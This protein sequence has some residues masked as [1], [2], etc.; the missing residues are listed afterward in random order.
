VYESDVQEAR[1]VTATTARSVANQAETTIKTADSIVASIVERVEAEGTGPE[2]RVRFYRLM[3]SLA[4][5]LPAIHE[6]GI[7]DAD[8]NAIVKSLVENSAG[9]NYSDREY[10]RYH[11]THTDRGPFIG[12]RIKSK[13]DGS[14]AITVTRRINHADGSF[15]GVVV[16]SVS[17]NFFQRLFD[18]VLAKSGGIIALLTDD[19]TVLV[20]SPNLASGIGNPVADSEFRRHVQEEP[21]AGGL[22]YRSALDGVWRY[23]SYQH[24]SDFPLSTL[25]SQSE[26]E[27]QRSFRSQLMWNAAILVC[28][29]VVVVNL[30]IRALKANRLLNAQAMQDGLTGLANRRTFDEMIL[31]EFRIAAWTGQ[32]ISM[33]MIDIDHFKDY[34][35]SYG[36]PAGDECL[37]TIARTVQGCIRRAGDLVARYGGEEMVVMLPGLDAARAKA[38]AETMRQAVHDLALPHV[39]SVHKFV[40]LSAGVA[41]Y[42][43]R[44]SV[45]GWRALIERADAA[46]YRAKAKGRDFVEC[47]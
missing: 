1:V 20:R 17:L 39:G 3:T 45:G 31:R 2:A 14:Y 4:A 21:L 46:L 32:P 5:A 25:V 28:V 47:A 37:R 26:W 38:L 41:T 27:V 6:M 9:L 29:A 18:Q 7:T 24:L 22:S 36:H 10:F 42:S 19:G 11:A 13:I 43:P 15:A 40:T 8:G 35:D 44:R 34:N 16:T 23:G 33:V 12:A 30:G